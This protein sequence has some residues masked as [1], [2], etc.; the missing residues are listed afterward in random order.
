MYDENDVG[1]LS[2]AVFRIKRHRHLFFH[3]KESRRKK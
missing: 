3:K 1:V 2:E